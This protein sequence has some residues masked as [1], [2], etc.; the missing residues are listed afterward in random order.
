MRGIIRCC[1]EH[2]WRCPP[3]LPALYPPR[4]LRAHSY[5]TKHPC[6]G[7]IGAGP[8]P[9]P[10]RVIC[11]R[12]GSHLNSASMDASVPA[13][14]NLF[15]IPIAGPVGAQKLQFP[16]TA[17]R[18]ITDAAL[19]AVK[20]HYNWIR[21]GRIALRDFAAPGA[22]KPRRLRVSQTERNPNQAAESDYNRMTPSHAAPPHAD[23][24]CDLA[25]TGSIDNLWTKAE[26]VNLLERSDNAN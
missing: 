4:L 10:G 13:V 24:F 3:L 23:G 8:C 15:S 9:V 17:K 7:N 11:R 14:G 12:L 25:Q 20:Y 18:R 21:C 6:Y 1:G 2:A 5:A 26:L 22:A 16:C 19:I